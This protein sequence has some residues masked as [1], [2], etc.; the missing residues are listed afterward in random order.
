[1]A[2]VALSVIEQRYRAVM[3][4]LDGASVSEVA[5]EVGVSRQSVH[6]WLRRYRA[7]GLAGLVDR[8][9]RTVSCPH[10]ASAELEAV[11]CEL[12]RAHPKWGALRILHELMRG[13]GAAGAV[14]VALDGATA[15]WSA[16]GW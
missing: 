7:A 6:A 10:R 9:H 15:S 5:A 4:V 11:V 8:S 2:L 14:A 1:M 12:R 3:A 13:A 16:T